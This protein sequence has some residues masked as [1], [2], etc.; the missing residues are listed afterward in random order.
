MSGV[1]S[2]GDDYSAHQ[3]KVETSESATEGQDRNQTQHWTAQSPE[4]YPVS[5]ERGTQDPGRQAED[6]NGSQ[7]HHGLETRIAG[8]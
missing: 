7:N 3:W 1:P 4:F 2:E 6:S 8:K 5:A